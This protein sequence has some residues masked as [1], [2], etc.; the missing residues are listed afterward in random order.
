MIFSRSD[1]ICRGPWSVAIWMNPAHTASTAS[2]RSRGFS[3]PIC[4]RTTAALPTPT[5]APR[6]AA[7]RPMLR[8]AELAFTPWATATS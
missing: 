4:S 8:T 1:R 2:S 5:R 6:T 7:A 3:L